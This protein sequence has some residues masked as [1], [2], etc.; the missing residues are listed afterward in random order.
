MIHLLHR[1][2]ENFAG[3]K[4]M[5]DPC[6][7]RY[8]TEPLCCSATINLAQV[9]YIYTTMV[10]MVDLLASSHSYISCNARLAIGRVPDSILGQHDTLTSSNA[11][12]SSNI[13]RMVLDSL[14]CLPCR[15]RPD[16]EGRPAGVLL[17]AQRTPEAN[18]S[19]PRIDGH[20]LVR[21]S[22][23]SRLDRAER[24]AHDGVS[25]PGAEPTDSLPLPAAKRGFSAAE[26]M[27]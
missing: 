5:L 18:P 4:S 14:A 17:V 3:F 9:A 21:A 1:L 13:S 6:R 24:K 2:G 25:L 20:I 10:D 26:R 15:R 7:K 11:T 12:T 22:S 16:M 23:E 8:R 27:K 19:I